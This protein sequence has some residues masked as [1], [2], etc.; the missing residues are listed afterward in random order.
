MSATLP[1]TLCRGPG[2]SHFLWSGRIRCGTQ[3]ATAT[4]FTGA[5]HCE[6]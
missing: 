6:L 3:P 4:L 1:V 2:G 5:Y